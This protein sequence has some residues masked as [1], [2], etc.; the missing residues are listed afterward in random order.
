M[1][2][3]RDTDRS[4]GEALGPG[5]RKVGEAFHKR[6]FLE[7]LK[8]GRQ[9]GWVEDISRTGAVCPIHRDK[10]KCLGEQKTHAEEGR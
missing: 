10:T 8:C 9:E 1:A 6:S 3:C 5:E 7:K 4:R 2:G